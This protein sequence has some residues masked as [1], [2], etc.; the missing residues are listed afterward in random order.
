VMEEVRDLPLQPIIVGQFR[1]IAD[2]V[3]GAHK[4]ETVR[5]RE[6]LPHG[7]YFVGACAFFGAS[8]N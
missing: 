4:G 1:H 3:V 7:V 2:V 5:L 6:E 8:R